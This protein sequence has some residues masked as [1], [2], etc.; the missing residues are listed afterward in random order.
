MRSRQMVEG[1][2]ALFSLCAM[3]GFAGSQASATH[4]C[5]SFEDSTARLACYDRAFGAPLKTTSK[6]AESQIE[7]Q[8]GFNPVQVQKQQQA[9]ATDAAPVDEKIM[10]TIKRVGKQPTGEFIATLDNDQVWVQRESNSR[11]VLAVGESVT[12]RKA[13][14]GSY[15]LITADGVATRVRR[16][17]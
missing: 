4:A 12:I 9:V 14:L 8:F 1:A 10:A 16:Q 5:A 6:P 2:L 3:P 15:F 17:K 13:A 11:A 7:E